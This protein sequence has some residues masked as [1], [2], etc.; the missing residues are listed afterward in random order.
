MSA[1]DAMA[2]GS[3][4]HRMIQKRQGSSYKAEV[5]LS[6]TFESDDYSIVIEGRADGILTE[7]EKTIYYKGAYER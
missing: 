3:R 7:D 5:P 1:E 2:E 4:I 6:Y